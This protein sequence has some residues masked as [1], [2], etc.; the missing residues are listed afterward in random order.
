MASSNLLSSHI[1]SPTDD[2]E[3]KS[4]PGAVRLYVDFTISFFFYDKSNQQNKST[5]SYQQMIE[6]LGAWIIKNR[7]ITLLFKAVPDGYESLV[8]YESRNKQERICIGD[9]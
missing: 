8:G 6:T 1:I 9:R 2:Y 3:N 7:W 5:T 4:G